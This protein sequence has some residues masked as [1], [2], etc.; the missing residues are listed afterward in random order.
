M[1]NI[2]DI[3]S[4]GVGQVVTSRVSP[5]QQLTT[6]PFEALLQTPGAPK[7]KSNLVAPAKDWDIIKPGVKAPGKIYTDDELIKIIIK[8]EK[9]Y[10]NNG[11]NAD[12]KSWNIAQDFLESGGFSNEGYNKN[13]NP[14]AIMFPKN[15]K[16][17]YGRKGTYNKANKTYYARFSSLDEYVKEKK[18]VLMLKPGEPINAQSLSDFVHRLKENNYFGSES[19]SNYLKGLMG[20]EQRLRIISDLFQDAHQK[21]VM[22]NKNK[23]PWWGWG[24]VAVG[25]IIVIKKITE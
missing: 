23:L 12:L 25:G 15:G 24:L 13:N 21:V 22:P 4:Y 5:L 8:L 1:S 10:D 2:W 19:E 20:S 18:Q 7:L 6:V 3:D 16:L 17:K 9:A 11:F 14:G